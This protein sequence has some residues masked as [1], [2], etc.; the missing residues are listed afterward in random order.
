MQKTLKTSEHF[1]LNFLNKYIYF[2]EGG[3]T[4]QVLTPEAPPCMDRHRQ[5]YRRFTDPTANTH[6]HN[7][8]DSGAHNVWSCANTREY[9]YC[10][11]TI[12]ISFGVT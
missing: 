1:L 5:I 7:D 6:A 12:L 8:P 3:R 2:Y 11:I 10:Q 4:P 9:T